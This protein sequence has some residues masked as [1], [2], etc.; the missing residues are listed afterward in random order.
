VQ[1]SSQLR[2]IYIGLQFQS[3]SQSVLLCRVNVAPCSKSNAAL[4]KVIINDLKLGWK[5][6]SKVNAAHFDS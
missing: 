6:R 1:I 4:R 3:Q 2:A 5:H